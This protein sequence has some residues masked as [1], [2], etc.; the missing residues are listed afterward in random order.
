MTS[1]TS[2][3]NTLTIDIGG[4][5]IKATVLDASGEMLI[6]R[7]RVNTP[8]HSHP[9]NILSAIEEVIEGFPHF[10]RVSVGFPGFVKNGH[11]KTAPNLDT[12]DWEDFPLAQEIANRLKKPVRLL[13][14]ADLLG[15]GVI[16][17]EGLELMI[18]LGTG[19]GTAFYMDGHLMPHLEL[20]HHPIKGKK[21]YDHYV[22]KA[23]FK[24]I[25]PKKWNKRM[26][27]I[28]KIM[29]II[30]NYDTL[31]IG[32][33]NSDKLSFKLDSNIYTVSNHQGIR[34]GVGVWKLEEDDLCIKTVHP[35]K[36]GKTTN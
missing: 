16:K 30:F 32:G 24:D 6:P 26:K 5:G 3:K 15:L 29:Q 27:K 28:L 1:E 23:A 14:D 17:G 10:E 9:E 13:N 18:T 11:V 12:E 25:G 31:F 4:S 36:I 20:S 2:G 22:G 34:G 35:E 19:F 33:G 21:D 8:D 7:N